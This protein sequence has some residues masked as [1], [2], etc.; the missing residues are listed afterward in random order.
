MTMKNNDLI[1]QGGLGN[2]LFQLAAL[3][4]F[5]EAGKKVLI[6]NSGDTENYQ[7]YSNGLFNYILPTD[8]EIS[9][10]KSNYLQT[11]TLNILTRISTWNNWKINKRARKFGRIILRRIRISFF[12][13]QHQLIISQGVGFTLEESRSTDTSAAISNLYIGYFQ[14]YKWLE[15]ENVKNSMRKLEL[16]IKNKNV[17]DFRIM[18]LDE[19]PL[20]MHI[21]MGDYLHDPRFKIEEDYYNRALKYALANFEYVNNLWIFTND[22][23]NASNYF[24]IPLNLNIRW[25]SSE[26]YSTSLSFEI[27]RFGKNYI[28]S[29][30]TYSYWGALLSIS[31]NVRVIAPKRW[32]NKYNEPLQLCPPDWIRL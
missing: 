30:S 27:L 15:K 9:V 13:K 16:K 5:S 2:Q 32:F 4:Y 11:K 8:I 25:I 7:K 26:D 20:I 17:E 31:T 28:I 14:S 3:L 21:R 19:K 23:K 10:V 6:I 18:A 29:N 22:L 12:T 24:D 1:L